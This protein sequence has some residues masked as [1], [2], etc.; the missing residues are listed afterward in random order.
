MSGPKRSIRARLSAA[1]QS[2]ITPILPGR[3]ST[4]RSPVP[5]CEPLERRVMLSDGQWTYADSSPLHCPRPFTNGTYSSPCDPPGAVPQENPNSGDGG[6][7]SQAV[8]Q[9][10]PA[11]SPTSLAPIRYFDGQ[12]DV[13][14][15]DLTSDSFGR[16]FGITR[17][18]SP[19]LASG[20][21]GPG[22]DIIQLVHLVNVM[23]DGLNDPN[24]IRADGATPTNTLAVAVS[25]LDNRFFDSFDSGAT[26]TE[27][28]GNHDTLVDNGTDIVMTDT[29]G[30][31]IHFY[32]YGATP[33]PKD[34]MFKSYTDPY[35]NSTSTVYD[36]PTGELLTVTRSNNLVQEQWVFAYT[37]INSVNQIS[38]VTLERRAG[39]GSWNTA[40]SVSYDYY[41]GTTYGGPLGYLKTATIKDLNGVTT[42]IW[43]YRYFITN[44]TNPSGN[45]GDLKMV[46][47]PRSS[48]LAA[49]AG[50]DPTSATDSQLQPYATNYFKYNANDQVLGTGPGGRVLLLG[51]NRSGDI[52]L[53]L[54]EES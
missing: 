35:G 37:T 38:S 49:N 42:G 26:Y 31:Q 45:V 29:T 16:S 4:P 24:N 28:N 54:F 36:D 44:D 15:T 17:S 33:T 40:R 39:N 11:P 6:K 22:W 2:A 8:T 13:S 52:H 25:G 5:R 23:K 48:A 1:V 18:W 47:D 10:P 50:F 20:P 41:D 30:G 21:L 43:G 51:G 19:S 14:A 7:G 34:G 12:P 9:G 53:R 3:V 32:R 27:R 46:F